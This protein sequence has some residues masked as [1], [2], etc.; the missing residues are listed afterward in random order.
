VSPPPTIKQEPG[1]PPLDVPAIVLARL[2]VDGPEQGR[3]LGEAMLVE[4][5]SRCAQAADT[6]FAR[7]VLAHAESTEARGFY[8]K[9]GFAASPTDPR[10]LLVRIKDVRKTFKSVQGPAEA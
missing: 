7:A 6:M 3:G 10:H 8:E 1:K 5:L 2:A 9:Y 4:A